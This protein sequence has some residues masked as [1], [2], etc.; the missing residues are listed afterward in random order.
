[1]SQIHVNTNHIILLNGIN[2]KENKKYDESSKVE[3]KIPYN[4]NF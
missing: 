3:F 4:V 2:N 1:M